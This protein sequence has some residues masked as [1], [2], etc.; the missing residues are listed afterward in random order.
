MNRTLHIHLLCALAIASVS[1]PAKGD[2]RT[3]NLRVGESTPVDFHEAYKIH[4]GRKGVVHLSQLENSTWQITALRSGVVAIEART[5]NHKTEITYVQVSPKA[6]ESTQRYTLT[7]SDACESGGANTLYKV[8]LG[9]RNTEMMKSASINNNAE[10][11]LTANITDTGTILGH[12]M[13]ANIAPKNSESSRVM[14]G[15]PWILAPLCDEVE[16]KSGGEDPFQSGDQKSGH[17]TQW[18]D[19]GM[20]IRFKILP[21]KKNLLKIPYVVTIRSPT[22]R[23]G[24]YSVSEMAS[25]VITANG[26][27]IEA[28]EAHLTSANESEGGPGFLTKIPIVG[29]LMRS[30]FG[31]ESSTSLRVLITVEEYNPDSP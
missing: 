4:V 30:L 23:S 31:A 3:I 16:I 17:S 10:F 28:G 12:S 26:T 9:L 18:R 6:T 14:N 22:S 20:S 29:P 2:P 5:K 24:H 21:V 19:H 7:P 11:N 25:T 8:T 13:T 27:T 15:D 1:S